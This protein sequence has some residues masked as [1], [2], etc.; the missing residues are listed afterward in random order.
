MTDK[1]PENLLRLFTPRPSLRYIPPTDKPPEH[2]K[3]VTIEPVG[4]YL[5]ALREY[6]ANDNSIPTESRMQRA[7]RRKRERK[8]AHEK[9]IKEGLKMFNPAGDPNVKG[10][11]YKTLFVARLDY[12]VE[13]RELER[14]FGRFGPIQRIRIIKNASAKDSDSLKKRMQGYCFIEYERERDMKVAYRDSDTILVGDRNVKVD[15]ERGRTVKDWRPRRL[16]GGLG[17]RHYTK[18]AAKPVG[19]FQFGGPPMGP[20]SNRGGGG[21]R[22]GFRGGFDGP[23]GGGGFR[24]GPRGGFGGRGGIGY[25]GS[26]FAG[27]PE[28]APAGPRGPRDGG[29]GSRYDDMANGYGGGGYGDRTG[30]NAEPVRSSR[31]RYDDRPRHGGYDDYSRKRR[32]EDNYD[33]SKRR[34]Y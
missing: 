29:Y 33:D 30:S 25:Q 6:K 11:P 20:G 4:N 21:F 15:C 13:P 3:T 17:G 23:R 34:R 18:A 1:L 8:E 32:H 24:G 19:G 28:G 5:G 31:D 10:D 26:G 22:G 27:A 9:R 2:R 16:G 14:A 12:R 7:D